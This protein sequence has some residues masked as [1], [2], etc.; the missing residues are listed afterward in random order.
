[1]QVPVKPIK[2][3]HLCWS[4]YY[5]ERRSWLCSEIRTVN[6]DVMYYFFIIFMEVTW[7]H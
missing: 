3:V 4:W 2:P 1:M 5:G 7:T 6:R